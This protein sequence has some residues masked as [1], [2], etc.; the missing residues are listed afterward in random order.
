MLIDAI[1]TALEDREK[2][3][4]GVGM[5]GTANVFLGS[6]RNGEMAVKLPTD[7]GI[8]V[9]FVGH[10]SAMILNQ[11]L[12]LPL[13]QVGLFTDVARLFPGGIHGFLHFDLLHDVF[14]LEHFGERS[15]E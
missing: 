4:S 7:A 10:E 11:K 15:E 3:F 8:D 14:R 5:N 1:N 12:V 13:G 2:S 9:R 6:V